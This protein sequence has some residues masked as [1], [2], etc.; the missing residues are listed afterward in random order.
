MTT[1]ASLKYLHVACVFVSIS[2]FV[3]RFVYLYR[4]SGKALARA[5]KVLPHVVDTL[6]L[7]AAIGMLWVLRI[8]PFDVNWLLAKIVALLAY[9]FFGALCL[10]SIPGSRRQLLFFVLAFASVSYIVIVALSKTPVPH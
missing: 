4:V 5:L 9:I 10:R 7:S 1:Y 3:F 6:L 2:L 8:N